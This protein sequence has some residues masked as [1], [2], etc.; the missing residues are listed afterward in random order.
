[1][2]AIR[3]HSYLLGCTVRYSV[4]RRRSQFRVGEPMLCYAVLHKEF[5]FVLG[6]N[7]C[8]AMP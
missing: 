6:E 5:Q 1:M 7:L 3:L 4:L 2:L 8:Y